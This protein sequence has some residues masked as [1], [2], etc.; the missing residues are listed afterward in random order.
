MELTGKS[1]TASHVSLPIESAEVAEICRQVGDYDDRGEYDAAA[2]ALGGWW[3]GVGVRPA[4]ECLGRL[5][6]AAILFSVGLLTSRIGHA[7]QL[8]GAPEAAKELLG[9]ARHIFMS[10]GEVAGAAAAHIEIGTCYWC[11][12]YVDEARIIFRLAVSEIDE[13]NALLKAKALLR[14]AQA[15]NSSGRIADAELALVEAERYVEASGSEFIRGLFRTTRASVVHNLGLLNN[16]TDYFDRVVMDYTAAK[17]HFEQAGNIRY[18]LTVENNLGHLYYL[19]GD[20]SQA[21]RHVEE[22]LTLAIALEDDRYIAQVEDTLAR[23]MIGE[24]H[25]QEALAVI[26]RTIKKLEQAD[27]Q[28]LLVEA[29]TTFA[30]ASARNGQTKAAYD[31]LSRA[32]SIGEH[33]GDEEGAGRAAL[34]IIE[35]IGMT[36]PAVKLSQIYLQADKLLANAQHKETLKRLRECARLILSFDT[37]SLANRKQPATSNAGT[38][39]FYHA[40]PATKEILTFARQVA[41]RGGNILI[42]GETGTGKEVLARLMHE[43]SGRPGQFVA[44]NCGTLSESLFESQIFGHKKGSFTGAN[45]NQIG[46]ARQSAGGTLFLDEIGDLTPVNQV[47]LLRMVDNHEV[48]P[49]GMAMP[50]YVDLHIIAATNRDLSSLV[51][52]NSFRG[53]LLY[54]LSNLEIKLPPLRERPLDIAAIAR[55]FIAMLESRYKTGIAFTDEA[56]EALQDLPLKGNA[57]ELKSLLERA[58]VVAHP[59]TVINASAVKVLALRRTGEGTLVDPWRASDLKKEVTAYERTLIQRALELSNGHINGAAQLLGLSHQTLSQ[60][61]QTKHP[62]LLS[63]RCPPRLRR[64]SIVDTNKRAKKTR[65]KKGR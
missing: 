4:V 3:E 20:Y 42:T 35:E 65:V 5:E 9:E 7:Q 40:E 60:K 51:E 30:V 19:S 28:S 36:L 43:W 18:C 11:Q 29:L 31:A 33:Y 46:A 21:R 58:F 38:T 63:V 39:V 52:Q 61:I 48:H 1:Q 8:A 27:Q 37:R 13:H 54:R 53:D 14:L 57:R 26:R 44:V 50:E 32:I 55:H 6:A 41:Q 2:N 10:E 56:I 47:K 25:Y 23:V 49:L 59:G 45:A 24:R 34:S 17:I 15:E 22:A 16:R 12:S 62:S 64:P